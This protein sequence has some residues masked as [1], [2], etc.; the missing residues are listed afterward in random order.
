MAARGA[1]NIG[2]FTLFNTIAVVFLMTL[3]FAG[4]AL[5]RDTGFFLFIPV[6][7][8][9]FAAIIPGLSVATRRFHD[10]GKSGWMLLLLCVLGIVPLVGLVCAIIQ[11][12]VLVPGQPARS[13]PVRAQPEVS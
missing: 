6:G 4:M 8:Y 10:V 11:I 7:I 12:V 3:A 13:K 9:G 5:S 2:C 1:R